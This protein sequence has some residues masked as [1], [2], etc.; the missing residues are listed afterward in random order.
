MY[1]NLGTKTKGIYP[2]HCLEGYK[3]AA[4]GG[5]ARKL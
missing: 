3:N 4:A 5:K 2:A 1:F